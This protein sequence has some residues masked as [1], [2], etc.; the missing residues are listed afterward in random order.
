MREKETSTQCQS[1]KCALCQVTSQRERGKNSASLEHS[2]LD[3]ELCP[4]KALLLKHKL[5]QSLQ[6]GPGSV[7]SALQVTAHVSPA[8]RT[9]WQAARRLQK[10]TRLFPI[11]K[12]SVVQL[13]T[14]PS[15][16]RRREQSHGRRQKLLGAVFR[17]DPKSSLPEAKCQAPTHSS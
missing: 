1:H 3:P 11:R 15:F 4:E 16:V 7:V 9:S 6:C 5:E 17:L 13:S 14:V 10:H 8:G 12:R 2:S